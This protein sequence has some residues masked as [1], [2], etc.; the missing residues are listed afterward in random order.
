M[1]V[2]SASSLQFSAFV[3][4]FGLVPVDHVPERCDVIGP[5]I[6]VIQVISVFPH[7][8]ADD[9]FALNAGDGLAHERT[10]LVGGGADREFLVR[11]DDEPGPAG[12]EAGRAGLGELFL[13]FVEAAESRGDR[14]AQRAFRRAAFA[15]TEDFPEETLRRAAGM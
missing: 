4:D 15:G 8:E 1:L 13:E 9:R 5:A 14:V 12:A 6:L 7:V 11:A 10:V 2:S 3:I